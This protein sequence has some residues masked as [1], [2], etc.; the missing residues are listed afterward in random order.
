MGDKFDKLVGKFK[1]TIEGKEYPFAMSI[2]QRGQY[3]TLRGKGNDEKMVEFLFDCF[4]KGWLLNH[5]NANVGEL[6]AAQEELKDFF[7]KHYDVIFT[8]VLIELGVMS[9]AELNSWTE[10]LHD[11]AFLSDVASKR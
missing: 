6:E 7:L 9:R 10:K 2:R 8:E 3:A 5:P 4:E 1:V 11:D